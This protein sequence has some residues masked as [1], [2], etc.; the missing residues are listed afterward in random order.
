MMKVIFMWL[1]RINLSSGVSDDQIVCVTV[2]VGKEDGLVWCPP[3][4]NN[5]VKEAIA[6]K[7]F[8]ILS[9]SIC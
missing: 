4:C 1:R 8:S 3:G 7:A 2:G 9:L 6:M 5:G